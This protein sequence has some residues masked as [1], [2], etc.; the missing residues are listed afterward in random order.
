MDMMRSIALLAVSLCA[1]A[2]AACSIGTDDDPAPTPVGAGDSG[3]RGIVLIDPICPVERPESPCPDRPFEAT[4][5]LLDERG[6]LVSEAYSGTDGRFEIVVAPGTYTLHPVSDTAP[7]SDPDQTVAV[8]QRAFTN[9]TISYDS[10][11]R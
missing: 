2:F 9:V 6:K 4:I 8:E 5:Q 10:G 1:F 3:I 7:P 11:I